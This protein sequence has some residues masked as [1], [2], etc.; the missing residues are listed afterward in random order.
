MIIRS[1]ENI[2]PVEIEHRL[3]AHPNISEAS[4]VGVDHLEMGQ[5]VKAIL[6]LKKDQDLDPDNLTDW[7][8]ETLAGYKIPTIWEQRETPLPRNASGK[9]VKGA[10]TGDRELDGYE[11]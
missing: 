11:D 1:G 2:Y 6:V 5:E 7:C 9:V 8:G 3:E 10:L 4:V